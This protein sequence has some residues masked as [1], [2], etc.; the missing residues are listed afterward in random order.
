M[1]AD[2]HRV[3]GAAFGLQAGSRWNWEISYRLKSWNGLLEHAVPW[4][5]KKYGQR[6]V[7][8]I[9]THVNLHDPQLMG[10]FDGGIVCH[11][12]HL[13]AMHEANAG[14][15][16][17]EI[18]CQ[19]SHDTRAGYLHPSSQLAIKQ[20][21]QQ[22]YTAALMAVTLLGCMMILFMD[23]FLPGRVEVAHKKA[24]IT[25]GHTRNMLV[26]QA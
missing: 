18:L 26:L 21:E 13:L 20:I 22:L 4:S 3:V 9:E 7:P 25:H 10:A 12:E 16:A 1:L 19:G 23:C 5:C 17:F 24:A 2:S 6:A 14:D 15:D 11:E 8:R